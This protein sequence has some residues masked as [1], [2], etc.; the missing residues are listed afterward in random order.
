MPSSHASIASSRSSTRWQSTSPIDTS[1]PIVLAQM[2]A[3]IESLS[4]SIA[5]SVRAG[6]SPSAAL[7]RSLTA[8]S[9]SM[10]PKVASAIVP[11]GSSALIARC[12]T[13]ALGASGP[14]P[15][16]SSAASSSAAVASTTSAASAATSSPLAGGAEGSSID[17]GEASMAFGGLASG[18][19]YEAI[20][21]MSLR[22]KSSSGMSANIRSGKKRNGR[23]PIVARKGSALEP[24]CLYTPAT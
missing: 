12:G 20:G 21:P 2:S 14:S 9:R 18:R 7:A 10:P 17:A 8:P 15:K 11:K 22:V 3:A 23:V 6:A 19:A 5:T 16:A 13:P 24:I 1:H 4:P